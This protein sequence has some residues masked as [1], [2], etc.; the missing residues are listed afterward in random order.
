MDLLQFNKTSTLQFLAYLIAIADVSSCDQ[1]A[2]TS[3][4]LNVYRFYTAQ[5]NI[6]QVCDTNS[7]LST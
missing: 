4:A 1:K 7:V 6:S 2:I 5:W 3:S